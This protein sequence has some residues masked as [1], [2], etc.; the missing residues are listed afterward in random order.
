[1]SMGSLQVK[2]KNICCITVLINNGLFFI[3]TYVHDGEE[4]N[5]VGEG[6]GGS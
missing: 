1:M 3:V 4:G 5:D 6:G 2:Y